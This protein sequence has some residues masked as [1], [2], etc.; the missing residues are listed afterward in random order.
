MSAAIDAVRSSFGR[1]MTK[2]TFMPRFYEIFTHSHPAIPQLFKNTNMEKQF[3][4]LGQSLN[5]AILFSQ[6]NPI[7]KNAIERIRK[8]HD[9]EHL[10]INPEL[11]PF[12]VDSLIA[13]LRESDPQFTPTLEQQWRDVIQIAIDQIKG[14]Y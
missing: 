5:M 1:A 14:G 12:W 13:A 3:D 9:R 11:Y 6:N 2:R 7:A 8:S 4:L 10:N